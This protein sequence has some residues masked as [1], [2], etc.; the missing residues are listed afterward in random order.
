MA[1]KGKFALDEL[2]EKI[3]NDNKMTYEDTRVYRDV[4]IY[5]LRMLGHKLT[6]MSMQLDIGGYIPEKEMTELLRDI[7]F[8]KDTG[9][10]KMFFI[11]DTKVV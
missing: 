4:L 3:A 1:N 7:D 10:T 8:I 9:H 6:S 5:K 11:N 2:T